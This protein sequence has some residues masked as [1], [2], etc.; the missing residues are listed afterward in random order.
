MGRIQR[1]L[2]TLREE[3][4]K[5]NCHVPTAAIVI[6]NNK[7]VA[8]SS[9]IK[10]YRGSSLHAETAALRKL[11]YQKKGTEGASVFIGRFRHD[12]SMGNAKPCANCIEVLK[13]Q[14]IKYVMW[15]TINE[16]VEMA[17][18][19]EIANDYVPRPVLFNRGL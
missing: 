13:L 17:A 15:T 3:Q 9:N 7:I 1:W 4:Q 10:G 8:K 6:R 14:G 18:V 19:D 16:T 2:M 5:S 12:G 11:R